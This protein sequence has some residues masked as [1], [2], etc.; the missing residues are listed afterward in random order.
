MPMTNID[1]FVSL[2]GRIETKNLEAG[3]MKNSDGSRKMRF[4]LAVQDNYRKKDGSQSKQDIPVEA[5]IPKEMV[6]VEDGVETLGIYST[7]RTGD[8]ISIMGHVEDNNYMKDGK[9][10]YGGILIRI[11]SLKHRES[12]SV[13]DAR[14]AQKAAAAPAEA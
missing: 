3:I 10:V 7:L 9:M 14:A 1:N 6:K 11:D 2:T 5:F 13:A 8:N 4:T 12:K